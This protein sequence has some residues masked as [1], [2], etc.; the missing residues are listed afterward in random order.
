MPAIAGT[1]NA[2]SQS[3]PAADPSTPP[4]VRHGVTVH[5]NMES[6]GERFNFSGLSPDGSHLHTTPPPQTPPPQTPRTPLPRTPRREAPT[7][8]PR[9]LRRTPANCPTTIGRSTFQRN[10]PSRVC[11]RAGT[12]GGRR[13]ADVWTFFDKEDRRCHFC[14]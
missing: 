6:P 8:T 10:P 13:A 9:S 3:T 14:E 2:P 5:F 11:P 12:R 1:D 7:Q 4:R